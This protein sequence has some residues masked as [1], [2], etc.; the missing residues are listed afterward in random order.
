MAS[1]MSQDL[2]HFVEILDTLD[3]I[4]WEADAETWTF[5]YINDAAGT[6]LGY[7]PD[8]WLG[9][10][11]FWESV[12]HPEDREHTLAFCREACRLA[13]DH[14]FD[15]RAIAADGRTVWLH[16][17][18]RVVTNSAG[19]AALLR[20]VMTDVTDRKQ[21]E[22]Q[23][24]RDIGNLQRTQQQLAESEERYRLLSELT[25]DYAW[26]LKVEES[27]EARYEWVS[28]GFERVTGYKAEL[29]ESGGWQQFIHPD[30]LGLTRDALA[31]LN[32]G[33][34]MDVDL[35][36][37]R[38]D[39][40]TIWVDAVAKPIIDE[41]GRL[42]RIV[43]SARDISER[44]AAEQEREQ[45]QSQLLQS[46]KMEAVG[47]L[48]G[49]V[50]HD[51]NNI[52]G[53][54]LNYASF[55]QQ[56]PDDR[57]AVVAD[58]REIMEAATRAAAL[59]RQLLM[60][61]RRETPHLER[62]DLNEVVT[63]YARFLE[64][65]LGEDVNL[66]LQLT[67]HAGPVLADRLNVEQILL[68]LAV[69]AR[70]AMPQGGTLTI[71]VQPEGPSQVRLSVSDTGH[72]MSQ[73]VA[74]RAFEPFFTTKPAGAGTG[75]GLAMVYGIAESL[76][77]TARLDANPGQ[78]STVHVIVPVTESLDEPEQAAPVSDF[79]P[80]ATLSI[81]VVEDEDQLRTLIYRMLRVDDHEVTAV[82]T[83]HEA[84]ELDQHLVD[85]CDLLLTDV[86]LPGM[87]GVE[88]V[89]TLRQRR[90]DLPVIYMSGYPADVIEAQGGI[91]A[92]LLEKP[93]GQVELRAAIE[94]E[95]GRAQSD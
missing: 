80:G 55:I 33:Q 75:L 47:R 59:T 85:T 60:L 66:Q 46:Q 41:T 78:G 57:D 25:S 35:R 77:G 56:N 21:A 40:A 49:G 70:D 2:K 69:N 54:I 42:V 26:S 93:F 48:A 37:I 63:D 24:V 15:Y 73:D 7:P 65:T 29:F 27:G 68:N 86:V 23:R 18:V 9:H 5:T 67:P 64:R 19:E 45:L 51:F 10:E 30:D 8:R 81:L 6:I 32:E 87:S 91:D 92:P 71:S 28:G 82:S 16:D 44:K 95:I 62:V 1:G 31:L 36:L 58:A 43:G 38:P 83:A 90:A 52:L 11:G 74:D 89:R 94:Q 3:A 79:H 13:T 72:G 14:E 4:V 88:L 50:A 61:S 20:G 34:P 76:G 12:I 84:L 39:G 53:A 22:E 17:V